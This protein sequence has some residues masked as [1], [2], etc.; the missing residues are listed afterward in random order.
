[1]IRTH[2]DV[3]ARGGVARIAPLVALVVVLAGS[4]IAGAEVPAE[5]AV[6]APVGAIAYESG[7]RLVK[8]RG[9][10]LAVARLGGRGAHR[11]T[12]P[13]A[14]GSRRRDIDPV[15]SPDGTM[16]A[17]T[18]IAAPDGG[19]YVVSSDGTGLRRL[20]AVPDAR[21]SLHPTWSPDGTMLAFDRSDP[22]CSTHGSSS[23]A[24]FVVRSD[25]S[26]RPVV[27]VRGTAQL[28]AFYG[29]AWAP[30]GQSLLYIQDAT[31]SG[32]SDEATLLYRVNVDGSDRRVLARQTHDRYGNIGIVGRAAWSPD[33][34]HI[35]YTDG[36]SGS[37]PSVSEC[38]VFV[39]DPDGAAKRRVGGFTIEDSWCGGD[40]DSTTLQTPVWEPDGR[41]FLVAETSLAEP[42]GIYE[43]GIGTNDVARRVAATQLSSPEWYVL[44][45]DGTRI[46]FL[47]GDC[48]LLRTV[49]LDHKSGWRGPVPAAWG[50]H[51][52]PAIWLP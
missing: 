22:G 31:P 44:S 19:L 23:S 9:S 13:P 11:V 6:A 40:G 17:F 5:R 15:W 2:V 24:V 35:A 14:P 46:S 4:A 20:A 26:A 7:G 34:A 3:F 10:W 8:A 41:K 38:S 50:Q 52:A 30:D 42:A 37:P 27:V 48:L 32:C 39:I 45:R 21:A 51:S 49:S 25:G 12:D 1:M 47:S 43:K 16:L 18:R 29:E 33:G 36:C 28:P